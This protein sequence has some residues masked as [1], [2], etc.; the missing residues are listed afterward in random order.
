M[1]PFPTNALDDIDREFQPEE[2]LRSLQES[3]LQLAGAALRLADL[4]G[5]SGSRTYQKAY[6]AFEDSAGNYQLAREMKQMV[7]RN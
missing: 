4:R 3:S 6:W 5:K 7:M 2:V 1:P